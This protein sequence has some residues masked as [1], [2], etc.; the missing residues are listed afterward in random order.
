MEMQDTFNQGVETPF[1]FTTKEFIFS[2]KSVTAL[3]VENN[4]VME[5][6]SK[7][8]TGKKRLNTN[9]T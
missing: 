4:I 6:S 8:A 5:F 1:Y 9:R 3:E 7:T 2:A